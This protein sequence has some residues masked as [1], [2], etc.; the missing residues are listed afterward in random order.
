MTSHINQIPQTVKDKLGLKDTPYR[1]FWAKVGGKE[2]IYFR[3]SWEFF[4]SLFLEKLK[5][6]GKIREWLHE[7]KTFWFEKI[8]RGVRSYLPDFLIIHLDGSEE[9]SEI[10]GMLDDRSRTKLARMKKYYPEVKLRVV[11]KEWFK[12]NLKGCMEL[13]TQYAVRLE[14]IN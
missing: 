7:P 13:E 9:W 1:Q 10:K 5:R 6:E 12:V 11:S 4:Y 8:K 2:P 14:K 3:S